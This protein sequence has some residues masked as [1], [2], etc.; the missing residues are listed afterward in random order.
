ML[1]KKEQGL[2]YEPDVEPPTL[3]YDP[4]T[5]TTRVRFSFGGS[6]EE[7]EGD[8]AEEVEV[9]FGERT[10]VRVRDFD[11]GNWAKLHPERIPDDPFGKFG[12]IWEDLDEVCA[13]DFEDWVTAL[14]GGFLGTWENNLLGALS[15]IA[16]DLTK[17]DLSRPVRI[18]L[19]ELSKFQ[20]FAGGE[21]V[22]FTKEIVGRLARHCDHV[23]AMV[24]AGQP[25][26]IDALAVPVPEEEAYWLVSAVQ[27]N[28]DDIQ[29]ADYDAAEGY[30]T[31]EPTFIVPD[32][33]EEID[34][35]W[36]ESLN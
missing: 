26:V 16:R 36:D 14:S 2:A 29:L 28:C 22:V 20:L 11:S 18:P 5:L 33:V 21:E 9:A 12:K 3:S 8:I 35:S 7:P 30:W 17:A 4:G 34:C 27:A 31:F 15:G 32:D 1:E 13:F 24:W 23:V 6:R 25:D 19:T 10:V